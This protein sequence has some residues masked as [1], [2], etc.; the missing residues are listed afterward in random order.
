MPHIGEQIGPYTLVRQLGR[1]A[2]GLV[3]LA[4]RR[5]AFATTQVAIKL[6]LDDEPDLAAIAKESQLW[7]KLGNH[8]NILPIIEAD[9]Y[10]DQL[11]IVSEY[12]PDGSLDTWLKKNNGIAPSMES[13]IAM[14][15]GILS[16]L[17]HLHSKKVVHRDLKPANILLHGETP[18][19]ADFGLARVLKSSMQSVGI[20]G[21]PAYMAPEVFSGERTVES[22][23]WSAGVILYQMISGRLPF[24][25]TDIMAL[26]GAIGHRNPDSLPGYVPTELAQIIIKALQK[27][28][29]SRFS[30]AAE[31]RAALQ[32]VIDP[33]L[34]VALTALSEKDDKTLIT[35]NTP[36]R[37]VLEET[38]DT[39]P[40]ILLKNKTQQPPQLTIAQTTLSPLKAANVTTAE[41]KENLITQPVMALAATQS[42]LPTEQQISLVK[43]ER[44]KARKKFA[45]LAGLAI[46]VGLN[47]GVIAALVHKDSARVLTVNQN[48]ITEPVTPPPPPSPVAA[49][50]AYLKN[51]LVLDS[52][53]TNIDDLI[54]INELSEDNR[55]LAK[56]INKKINILKKEVNK[57]S[58]KEEK[59]WLEDI[60]AKFEN[61]FLTTTYSEKQPD[62]LKELYE[63]DVLTLNTLMNTVELVKKIAK[64]KIPR[65]ETEAKD[66]CTYIVPEEIAKAVDDTDGEIIINGIT[67][68]QGMKEISVKLPQMNFS[69]PPTPQQI[70]QLKKNAEIFNKNLQIFHQI[71]NDKKFKEASFWQY[72]GAKPNTKILIK[73]KGKQYSFSQENIIENNQENIKKDNK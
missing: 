34:S 1:G 23:L 38:A 33:K 56:E 17:E 26:I 57:L 36:R 16:G 48:V 72:R 18:R 15:M 44:L 55:E 39:L 7:S 8:P 40:E 25:H 20:A 41:Q 66:S 3:W 27:D 13:A 52:G 46:A 9:K 43:T 4:E 51:V 42:I 35:V 5:S 59:I 70:E 11:V 54:E 50:E 22:D 63:K 64:T 29:T 68:M 31:M 62:T 61:N 37:N 12:A 60:L 32:S 2:F 53:V 73:D 28:V 6:A 21:T 65:K 19:L 30:S 67:G 47:I 10:D 49:A 71:T 58:Q 45:V 24:P 14:T 69:I